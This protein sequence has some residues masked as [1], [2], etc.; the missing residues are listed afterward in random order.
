MEISAWIRRDCEPLTRAINPQF[1]WFC[2][3]TSKTT[4]PIH[5]PQIIN[6]FNP[7]PRQFAG[8]WFPGGGR[9]GDAAPRPVQRAL[10]SCPTVRG[11][12]TQP[13]L[14][15]PPVTFCPFS[16]A[17]DTNQAK[18]GSLQPVLFPFFPSLFTISPCQVP[19]LPLQSPQGK[20][21]L[22]ILR[23]YVKLMFL[24]LSWIL[25]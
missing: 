8:R 15:I 18:P 11:E 19:P 25:G 7:T 22:T 17:L 9:E 4:I 1:L 2:F 16:S 13:V 23:P 5:L 24:L 14:S 6:L 10:R 21:V 12:V 20:A 3:F